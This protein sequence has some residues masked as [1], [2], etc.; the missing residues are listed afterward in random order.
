MTISELGSV[1][2]LIG[3][4]ATVA[5]LLYLALQ[6]RANTLADKYKAINDIIDRIVGWQSNGNQEFNGSMIQGTK[7]HNDLQIENEGTQN[8][9]GLNIEEQVAV[10][11]SSCRN[12]SSN[13]G[14]IR[15]GE[16]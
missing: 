7:S 11:S 12:A 2:E 5:T 3:A 8:Y 4:I 13:R 9:H 1:G 14:Y 10:Y 15:N 6:I 16:E